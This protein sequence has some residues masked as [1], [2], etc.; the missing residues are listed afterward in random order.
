MIGDIFH[1]YYY[2]TFNKMWLIIFREKGCR[3]QFDADADQ[4]T[5]P[6]PKFKPKDS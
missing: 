2:N 3:S 4:G 6:L 5:L 1:V